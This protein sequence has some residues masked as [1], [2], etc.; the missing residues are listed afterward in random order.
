MNRSIFCC[1]VI[2]A[3]GIAFCAVNIPNG[4]YTIAGSAKNWKNELYA[5]ADEIRV[6]AV[7]M[8]GTILAQTSVRD[9]A[10]GDDARNFALIVPLSTVSSDKTAAVGDDV[11]LFVIENG[12]LNMAA[13][14]VTLS[15]S[16]GYTNINLKVTDVRYF[17]STSEYAVNGKVAVATAYVEGLA[18]W[19]VAYGREG[20]EADTDWDGDGVSNYEEYLAG[21]NPFD[22]SDRLRI[23]AISVKD[24]KPL[25]SF[26]YVGGHVYGILKT[27]TLALPDWMKEKSVSFPGKDDDGGIATLELLPMAGEKSRFF[28][29]KPE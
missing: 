7:A 5:A 11:R 23:T 4:S 1:A 27:T 26:E 6:Q 8:D 19:L 21:T 25:L 16:G 20:Y 28:T 18:P 24:D 29:V 9:A 3:A 15:E 14:T 10:G 13:Q 12:V 22:S 17:D 2:F